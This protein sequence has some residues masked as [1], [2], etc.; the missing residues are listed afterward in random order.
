MVNSG[1]RT[2]HG[3]VQDNSGRFAGVREAGLTS[4]VWRLPTD[5]Q[6]LVLPDDREALRSM[7][8]LYAEGMRNLFD[9]AYAPNGDLFGVENGPDRDV[10]EELNWMRPGH[11]YGFPWRMALEDNPEQFADYD[12]TQ[13]AR[14]GRVSRG[15]STNDPDFPPPPRARCLP[16]P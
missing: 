16:I 4:I 7:G 13:D 9:F 15:F 5:A 11:H 6:D 14:I 2:D 8:Y 12:P 3:E 10:A 1:S